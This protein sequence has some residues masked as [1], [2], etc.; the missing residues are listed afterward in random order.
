M[1]KKFL[2][3]DIPR[4]SPAFQKRKRQFSLRGGLLMAVPFLA[5]GA[6]LIYQP[7]YTNS[8]DTASRAV[9]PAL[10]RTLASNPGDLGGAIAGGIAGGAGTVAKDNGPQSCKEAVASVTD[11]K[12]TP[13]SSQIFPAIPDVLRTG[14]CTP[15]VWDR[16]V[17]VY[18]IAKALIMLN[19]F[20][21]T[22]A[23]LFTLYAGLLY[24]S[25][26]AKEDNVKKAKTLLIA[27]Y[28]GLAIVLLARVIIFS[29]VDL[30]SDSP[31]KSAFDSNG[32]PIYVGSTPT[33]SPP[34]K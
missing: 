17:I 19:W 10:T 20:A 33:P 13:N 32:L 25:G 7:Q 14:A 23:I 27:T 24:I 16:S 11:G 18:L 6:F 3:K 22:L 29:A 15:A 9:G 1:E 8:P 28:V 30:L 31:S 26:F 12:G 2:G 34:T 21:T 5:F 4:Q